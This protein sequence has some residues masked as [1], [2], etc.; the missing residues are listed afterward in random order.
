MHNVSNKLV[1]RQVVG[2]IWRRTHHTQ[3]RHTSN[4]RIIHAAIHPVHFVWTKRIKQ[5][6]TRLTVVYSSLGL[7]IL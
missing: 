3:W 6:Q 2:F 1:V 4:Y 7:A 5:I